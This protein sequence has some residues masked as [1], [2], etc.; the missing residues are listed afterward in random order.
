[1]IDNF[2]SLSTSLKVAMILQCAGATTFAAVFALGCAYDY[3]VNLSNSDTHERQE[4]ST[5]GE[6][7]PT[8]HSSAEKLQ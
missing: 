8:E 1:M 6:S 4:G 5:G 2:P 7:P 3:N